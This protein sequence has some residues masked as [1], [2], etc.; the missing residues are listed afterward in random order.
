M[1]LDYQDQDHFSV[2]LNNAYL[3]LEDYEN[4]ESIAKDMKRFVLKFS[5]RYH[6]DLHGFY[7]VVIYLN[8]KVGMF[9]EIEKIDTFELDM[10]SVDFKI[11]IYL[12]QPFYLKVADYDLL[13]KKGT[14]YYFEGSYY[15]NIDHI[16]ERELLSLLELGSIVYGE[17]VKQVEQKGFPCRNLT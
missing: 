9:I 14:S 6:L 17:E 13:P 1:R 15:L 16:E 7:R 10:T 3:K 8:Q 2:Y 4:K 5:R 12:R 11:V